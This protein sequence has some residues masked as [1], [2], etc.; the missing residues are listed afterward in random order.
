MVLQPPPLFKLFR[1][2]V[3]LCCLVPTPPPLYIFAPPPPPRACRKVSNLFSASN[4][5][6]SFLS[7]YHTSTSFFFF[8][9]YMETSDSAGGCPLRRRSVEFYSTPPLSKLETM[10]FSMLCSLMI[11]VDL[12][13]LPPYLGL[14]CSLPPLFY[15]NRLKHSNTSTTPPAHTMGSFPLFAA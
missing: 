11:R 1:D 15:F 7:T 2:P 10:A 4:A 5:G 6:G 14:K 13:Y 12:H 3:I 9:P 8:F